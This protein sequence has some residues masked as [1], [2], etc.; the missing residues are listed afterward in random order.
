MG[1]LIPLPPEIT[2][3]MAEYIPP[4]PIGHTASNVEYKVLF[5]LAYAK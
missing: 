3:G 4:S 1:K 2:E 5:A